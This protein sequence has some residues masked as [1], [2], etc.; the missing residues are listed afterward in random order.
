MFH[1]VERETY[2]GFI[3]SAVGILLLE[4]QVIP[5]AN[6]NIPEQYVDLM[7]IRFFIQSTQL[8]SIL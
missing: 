8:T 4:V 2:E 1:H 3:S 6:T 7:E 5:F